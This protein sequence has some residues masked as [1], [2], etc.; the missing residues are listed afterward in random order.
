MSARSAREEKWVA[1]S[2]VVKHFKF[3]AS[4][5]AGYGSKKQ[6][7]NDSVV[8]DD[9]VEHFPVPNKRP[10]SKITING[11]LKNASAGQVKKSIGRF[12]YETGDN[13]YSL[14]LKGWILWDEVKEMQE[15]VKKIRHSWASTG[16]SILLDGWVNEKGQNLVSF[17][18]NALQVQF[19]HSADVSAII[20]DVNALQLLLDRAIEEVG[21]TM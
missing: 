3:E 19:S 1:S 12:F 5:T 21:M 18:V 11:Q 7:E 14:E 10:D 13:P 4:Q 2:N 9:V 20:N 6:L 17:V 8:E 16:C 15:Y